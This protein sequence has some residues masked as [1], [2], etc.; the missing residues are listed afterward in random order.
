VESSYGH[1]A[2][3]KQY[4]R[5]GGK[6]QFVP[7]VKQD[8]KTNLKHTQS[9]KRDVGGWSENQLIAHLILWLSGSAACIVRGGLDAPC[10]WTPELYGFMAVS[11][12]LAV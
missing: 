7:V 6:W 2:N 12:F 8:G 3:L 10:F 11:F 5:L 9:L 1:R 4:R